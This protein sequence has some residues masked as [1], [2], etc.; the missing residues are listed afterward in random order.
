MFSILF[1]SKTLFCVQKKKSVTQKCVENQPKYVPYASTSD[2]K[3]DLLVA[4]QDVYISSFSS[5]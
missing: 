1:F 4:N 3:S 5:K 2:S